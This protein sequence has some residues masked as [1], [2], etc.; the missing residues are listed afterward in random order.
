MSPFPHANM[1]KFPF[2]FSP[3]SSL[4]GEN[5]GWAGDM[6]DTSLQVLAS[7]GWVKCLPLIPLLPCICNLFYFILAVGNSDST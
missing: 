2:T 1:E 7:A 4:E 3:A 5:D 6:G